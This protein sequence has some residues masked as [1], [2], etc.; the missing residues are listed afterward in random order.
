MRSAPPGNFEAFPGAAH[1]SPF[2]QKG[3]TVL[4]TLRVRDFITRSVMSTLSFPAER[5]Y[6]IAWRMVAE[7]AAGVSRLLTLL[8]SHGLTTHSTCSRQCQR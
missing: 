3:S 2:R 7:N 5:T 1:I 8:I 6:M 4:L